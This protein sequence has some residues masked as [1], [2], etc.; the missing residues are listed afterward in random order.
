MSD[1][2]IVAFL[3]VVAA[4]LAL[5]YSIGYTTAHL[6]SQKG[7]HPNELQPPQGTR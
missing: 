5:S 7:N 1:L 4:S 3:G 6:R 2:M